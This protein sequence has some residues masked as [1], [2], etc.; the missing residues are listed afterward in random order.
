MSRDKCIQTAE[1]RFRKVLASCHAVASFYS[2]FNQNLYHS[3]PI[4]T[5]VAYPGILIQKVNVTS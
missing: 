2:R 5:V 4:C 3:H 1:L